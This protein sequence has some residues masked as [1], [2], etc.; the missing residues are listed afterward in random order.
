MYVPALYVPPGVC[1]SV[2]SLR[3]YDPSC[4]LPLRMHVPSAYVPPC[5]CHLRVYVPPSIYPL[6]MYI[7]SILMFLCLVVSSFVYRFHVYVPPFVSLL[8]HVPFVR[9]SLCMYV[10]LYVCPLRVDASF[11]IV[12]SCWID[13]TAA[14]NDRPSQKMTN[15]RSRW[16][17]LQWVTATVDDRHSRW[18]DRR[19]R[20][21]RRIAAAMDGRRSGWPSQYD[22][23]DNL[24]VS[25]ALIR[26]LQQ[27]LWWNIFC[28]A[29]RGATLG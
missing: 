17:S 8:L 11:L 6:H 21:R 12:S 29:S 3:V 1:S 20:W 13:S 15:R 19:D 23:D 4:A 24:I 14:V 5:V 22:D 28:T 7:P 27:M 2:L 16:P 18:P 26:S 25:S 9:M 10:S